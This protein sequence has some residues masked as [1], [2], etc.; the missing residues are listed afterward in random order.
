MNKKNMKTLRRLTG[1]RAF[2]LVRLCGRPD[3]GGRRNGFCKRLAGWRC[4]L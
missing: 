4:R 1:N 3:F 2:S